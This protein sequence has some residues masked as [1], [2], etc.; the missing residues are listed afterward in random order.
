MPAYKDERYNTWY[1]AFYYTDWQG[2]RV[3]K[4]KRGFKTKKEADEWSRN[5]L[6]GQQADF[7]MNF[8]EFVQI[9]FEDITPRIRENTINNKKNITKNQIL[10]YFAKKTVN[11]IK[12]TDI[13]K[14]QNIIMSKNYSQT[15]MKSIHNQMSAIFN[16][17]VNYYDLKSNPCAKAGSIG[18]K[19][20]DEMDFWTKDEFSQFIDVMM[21]KH[22]SYIGFKTL[23][24]TGLRIGELLALTVE[25]INFDEKTLRV[26]KSYQRINRK[27]VITEP[28]TPKSNRTISIPDFLVEDLRDYIKCMYSREA[29][30]RL[31]PIS[32]SYFHSEMKRGCKLSGVKKIRLHDTRHSHCAML[33]DMNI[34]ILEVSERLGHEKVETTLNIYA[35]IYPNKQ[36]ELSNKLNEIYGEKF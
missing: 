8:E 10:P 6:M 20:A 30:D 36:K 29:T 1:T 2:K 9:Y 4:M 33:F 24:W 27:D 15:Y 21:D 12:A 25:D 5:F 18:K 35:H 3:K 22:K 16:F 28:K 13:R 19:Q 26:C 31:F 23:F 14:W 32:K 34:P 7:N 17:A 11:S